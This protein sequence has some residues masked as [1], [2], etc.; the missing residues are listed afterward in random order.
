METYGVLVAAE[1][2]PSPRSQVISACVSDCADAEKG[3]DL[4]AYAVFVSARV[5]ALILSRL[6]DSTASEHW[7]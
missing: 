3:D 6:A 4:Q 5:A 1:N 7:E 2:C